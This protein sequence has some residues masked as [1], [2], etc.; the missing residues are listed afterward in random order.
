MLELR[1]RIKCKAD[2]FAFL[3]RRLPAVAHF[4]D[5]ARIEFGY[6]P[7][8]VARLVQNTAL[9]ACAGILFGLAAT[10]CARTAVVF[11]SLLGKFF[12]ALLALVFERFAIAQLVFLVGR[13]L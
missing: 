10:A 12:A 5:L 8:F 1:V 9:D 3:A 6:F 2:G 7:V 13:T 11:D 4:I